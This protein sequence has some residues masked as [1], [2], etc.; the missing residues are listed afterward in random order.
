[1]MTPHAADAAALPRMPKSPPV[2]RLRTFLDMIKFSH[3][4][5]AMPFALIA[6]FLAARE[7]H[8]VWPGWLRLGLIILCMVMARTFAMTFNRLVDREFDSR[9]PRAMRRPSVTGEITVPFMVITLA[10]CGLLFIAATWM[11]DV[12]LGNIYPVALALPV[13][14]WIALYSFTK[15]FTWL[16]HFFLGSSLALAPVSAWIAIVPPHGPALDV[17]VLLV[18]GAVLFWLPGFDILYAMQDV[19]IDRKEK[20]FSLPAQFGVAASLWISR[21]CHFIVILLLLAFGL[22]LNGGMPMGLI[23][24]IGFSAVVLLLVVEQSLV[25]P[26]D[27]SKV[28]LAF[29]TINGLVGLIFGLTTIMAIILHL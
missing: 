25:K 29:M 5:F 10:I 7:I 9:N 23:Y 3:S 19:D 22:G 8:L 16:C 17:Q 18:A 24:W 4:I 15:R 28:N 2:K 1:M 11:F 20:L 12:V 6:T 13:L 14:L 26:H 21:V 27:I